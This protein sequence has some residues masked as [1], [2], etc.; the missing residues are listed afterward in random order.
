MVDFTLPPSTLDIPTPRQPEAGTRPDAYCHCRYNG[1]PNESTGGYCMPTT[2]CA[3]SHT[4]LSPTGTVVFI[5][6]G[7]FT[8]QVVFCQ[9]ICMA[10]SDSS[11]FCPVETSQSAL[12][13][14]SLSIMLPSCFWNV[15][16]GN[17]GAS[18]SH[19]FA[20]PGAFTATPQNVKQFWPR[21]VHPASGVRH[22]SP[23]DD[24]VS[25]RKCR[26]A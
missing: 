9:V 23:E 22:V 3:A 24:L 10:I 16:R 17:T 8:C 12:S 6:A 19:T 7:I 13:G 21:Y 15:Q 25:N 18:T 11:A 1:S 4:G 5:V 14:T 20:T 2:F 26:V